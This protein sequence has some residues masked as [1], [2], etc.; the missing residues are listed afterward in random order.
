[1]EKAYYEHHHF[2]DPGFPL[3]F[4]YN[5]LKNGSFEVLSHWHINIEL[6]YIIEGTALISSNAQ[7]ITANPGDIVV[8]NS[9]FLHS[10]KS[11]SDECSYYCLIIDKDHC[12]S[13]GFNTTNNLFKVITD[14]KEIQN[15]YNLIIKEMTN[16][17]EYYKIATVALCTT[18][19]ILL[20]RHLW[21]ADSKKVFASDTK[22]EIVK[23]AIEYIN[24]N[25]RNELSVSQICS[26][27]GVSKFYFCRTFK[28]ITEKTAIEYINILR[29]RQARFLISERDYMIHEAAE[30]C[31]FNSV[32]YFSKCFKRFYGYSPSQEKNA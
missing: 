6:L 3:I 25:Y 17:K 27:I 11:V 22:T 2:P 4:H 23:L 28:E 31:G 19:L 20:F 13:L 7:K 10:I 15:I 5:N 24:Q 9:N 21:E 26:A 32:S 8:V 14:H 18:M 12:D 29:T 30:E 16:K 1:M